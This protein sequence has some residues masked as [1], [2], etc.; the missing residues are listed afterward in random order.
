MAIKKKGIIRLTATVKMGDFDDKQPGTPGI[1]KKAGYLTIYK[2]ELVLTGLKEVNQ[3]SLKEVKITK[4]K[5][6][7]RTIYSVI[8]DTAA[9]GRHFQ[10]LYKIKGSTRVTGGK[11]TAPKYDAVQAY[12][13]GWMST[14]QIVGYVAKM[15]KKPDILVTD[16]NTRIRVFNAKA[17]IA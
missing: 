16:L 11:R 8:D 17:R 15:P 13:P 9:T 1:L 12:F 7:G 10:F 6:A 5:L 4:G 14:R 2:D 3:T